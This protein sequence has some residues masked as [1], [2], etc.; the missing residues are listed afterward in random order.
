[1]RINSSILTFDE[2][3]VISELEKH[4]FNKGVQHASGAYYMRYPQGEAV[5]NL[6]IEAGWY[7]NMLYLISGSLAS[8]ESK[9]NT[10]SFITDTKEVFSIIKIP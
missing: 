3:H 9:K 10:G 1:M 2:I 4:G 6:A 8:K 5:D 7:H